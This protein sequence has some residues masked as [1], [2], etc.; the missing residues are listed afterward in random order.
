MKVRLDSIDL[1]VSIQCRA[2]ID[3][4][5]VNEYAEA[6]T[7]GDK[8]PPI[9]LFG[10]EKRSWIGD[11]WQRVLAARQIGL[12]TIDADLHSGGRIAAL[13]H[14]LGANIR[15]G[16]RRSNADKR[17]CVEIALRE[18]PKLS[19][20]AIAEMCGVDKN[21]VEAV[22][23][24]TGENH[25]LKRTGRD[26]KERPA[27]RESAVP[28]PAAGRPADENVTERPH[29]EVPHAKAGPPSSGMMFAKIAVMNL[30]EIREDDMERDQAFGHVKGWLEDH[31]A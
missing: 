16:L 30:E 10:T 22:R 17:R 8:F 21:T 20:R 3:T 2:S 4:G 14:A 11:G 27:H 12:H 1:D 25:Q 26:G 5:T 31:G 28:A 29:S 19:N 7:A 23:G 18:F 13:K 15:H 24:P 9:A 6:M